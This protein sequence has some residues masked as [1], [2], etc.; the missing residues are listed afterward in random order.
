MKKLILITILALT[1]LLSWAR[2]ISAIDRNGSWYYLYDE[3]GR[4][5]KTL[6]VNTTGNI[7]G[8]SASFFVAQNGSWIYLYDAEGRKYKTLSHSSTGDV[9]AVS[10]NTFVTRNGSWIYTYDASGKKI[11]TRAAH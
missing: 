8:W 5:Y 3:N 2:S 9:I 4:K 6:S 10:G 11:N 1:P 7:V